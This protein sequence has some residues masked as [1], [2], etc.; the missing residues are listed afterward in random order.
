MFSSSRSG[1]PNLFSK[2]AD[3]TGEV[4]RLTTSPNYQV[5]YDFSPDGTRLVFGEEGEATGLDVG[6]LPMDDDLQTEMLLQTE[7]RES[8]PSL[9]PDGRWMAYV[10]D[11]SGEREIY[12]RPFP[13]VNDARR[14]I[15]SGF[16]VAPVWGP[17]GRE[18]FYQTTDGPDDPVRLMVVPVE[19]EPAFDSGI[20]AALFEGPY[21]LGVGGAVNPFDVSQ[22]GQ[23]FLMIKEN[24]VPPSERPQ[25]VI[26]QNWFEELKERVP[27]DQ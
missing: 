18:L 8:Q 25:I 13:N 1:L 17:D 14:Q 16:G 2:S 26:V 10:S 12:V 15:P 4:R 7:F 3:G 19:T 20:P 5:A 24:I 21:R 11:E 22:N 23:R 9:S 6:V 27:T